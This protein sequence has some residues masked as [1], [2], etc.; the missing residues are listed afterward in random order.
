MIWVTYD[1]VIIIRIY[2]FHLI[3]L[4]LNT[5]YRSYLYFACFKIIRLRKFFMKDIIFFERYFENETL[6]KSIEAIKRIEAPRH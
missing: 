5:R 6:F 4:T 3:W 1:I 2:Q